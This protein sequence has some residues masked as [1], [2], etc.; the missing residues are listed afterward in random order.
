MDVKE[1]KMAPHICHLH[2]TAPFDCGNYR[3]SVR[4]TFSNNMWTD[5]TNYIITVNK[6]PG[7]T[8]PDL[9]IFVIDMLKPYHAMNMLKP[10][11]EECHVLT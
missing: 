3:P 7:N 1:G 11:H 6:T 10:Y 9:S 2:I 5:L 4:F 8:I